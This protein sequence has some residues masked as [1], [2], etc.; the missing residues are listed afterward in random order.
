MCC[1][2]MSGMS[3]LST[4]SATV[5][6]S[7]TTTRSTSSASNGRRLRRILDR[8][9][10]RLDRR[11]DRPFLD[12]GPG[13]LVPL[14][15]LLDEHRRIARRRVRLEEVVGARE[16]VVD[17]G[18]AELDEQRRGDAVARRHAAEHEGL[19]D[20]IGVA[21]PGRDARRLLRGVVE[22][23]AHLLRVEAG[24][25]AGGR[26]RAERAGDAVRAAVA[27]VSKLDAAHRHRDPRADVVAERHGAEEARRRR[28]RAPRRPPA[29]PA[30]PRTRDAT[31]TAECES[32]VSSEWAST[33]LASAASIGAG[34]QARA[35][36]RG[37]PLPA[38]SPRVSKR[39]LAGRQLGP[40]NHRGEGIED[41]VLRLLD[42]VRRERAAGGAGHVRAE[43]GH[44]RAG[45]GAL[46]R[47]P[48]ARQHEGGQS[49]SG[50]SEE[51]AA[52][53]WRHGVNSY[54]V[55]SFRACENR[56]EGRRQGPLLS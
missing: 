39:R 6:A 33:P 10:R 38:Q 40:G 12:V 13:D 32:S 44:H 11:A 8:V 31:A 53:Q 7:R 9:E 36:N 34:D 20:V 56:P 25:A 29:P 27:L 45:A 35:G 48:H 28:S 42:D 24:A 49:K 54:V 17:A 55:S 1:R 21:L 30:R 46:R 23:P 18:P 52:R 2:Q 15:E 47:E 26:R 41:V 50:G 4:T 14:A 16:H 5:G 51:S 19:L 43:R 3:R 22:Q 37:R